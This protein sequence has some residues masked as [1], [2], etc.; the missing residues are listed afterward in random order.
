[1]FK[2]GL[3]GLRARLPDDLFEQGDVVGER[4]AAGGGEG[5][6]GERA[7]FAERFGD[8]D[9]ACLLQ[10]ADMGGDVA[11]GHLERVPEFG[12]GELRGRGEEGHDGET[13]L[14]VNDAVELKEGLRVHGWSEVPPVA[15]T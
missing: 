5:A 10:G 12:E 3:G 11:V 1:M 7:A 9:V 4:L 6:G 13:S 15:G 8:G 14:L 2:A